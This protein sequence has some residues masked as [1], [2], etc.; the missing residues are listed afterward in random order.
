VANIYKKPSSYIYTELY[1]DPYRLKK[2]VLG[3]GFYKLKNA[4]QKKKS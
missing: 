2:R 1:V 4:F 3:F